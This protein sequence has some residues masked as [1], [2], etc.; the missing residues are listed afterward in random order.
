MSEMPVP[1][2]VNPAPLAVV[3][4]RCPVAGV[5][6]HGAAAIFHRLRPGDSLVLGREPWNPHDHRAITLAWRDVMLGYV[7]REANYALAQMMDRG[8]VLEARILATKPEGESWEQVTVE[9]LA[10][11][12]ARP[13]EN[14]V[15]PP[16]TLLV[17]SLSNRI[18][19]PTP[20]GGA[21]EWIASRSAALC[22]AGIEHPALLPFL[23]IVFENGATRS[24]DDPMD[25]FRRL[26]AAAGMDRA[27]F[28]RLPQWTF[29][30]FSRLEGRW[31]GAPAVAQYANLLLRL[32][33]QE[34]PSPLVASYVIL[35]HEYR[36]PPGGVVLDFT[37]HP[38]WFVRAF[39]R[40]AE[41]AIATGLNE[42]FARGMRDCVDWLLQA[43]P[44]PDANQERAGWDW[45]LAQALE[46]RKTR[47]LATA[48]PWAVPAGEVIIGNWRVVPIRS[49]AD[50]MAEA[51]A[52]KNCLADYE[53]DC[54][55][56][57]VAIFSI[58]DAITDERAA[59]F[60][61][62]RDEDGSGWELEQVAGK[63][64]AEASAEMRLVAATAVGRIK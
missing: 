49:F 37:R 21:C 23:R 63:Q 19:G 53:E 1:Y 24:C 40:Q 17:R 64:N 48:A 47:A 43:Q 32:D 31:F 7:P 27:A 15:P 39:V 20:P 61:A 2:R 34:P 54:R 3:V 62:G 33:I 14:A 44:V 26:L 52:M 10:P 30:A 45:V 51:Q 25:A 12:P 4:L 8:V 13:S 9:I 35:L 29:K 56:G 50:L 16:E 41:R 36:V 28:K 5:R 42:P 18:F 22:L 46:Y 6:H 58:R 55:V 38:P 11:G 57:S 59:C 60:A